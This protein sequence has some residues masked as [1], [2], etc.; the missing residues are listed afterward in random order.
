[1][2]TN[3]WQQSSMQHFWGEIAPQ[4]HLVQFYEDDQSFL[5]TLEGFVGSGFIAKEGVIVIATGEHLKQLNERLTTNGFDLPKLIAGDFYMPIDA[6][7]A[8]ENFMVKGMPDETRFTKL[9]GGLIKRAKKNSGKFRAFGEMVAILLDKNQIEAM[10]HLEKLWNQ[11]CTKES[12]CLYCAYPKRN[13]TLTHSMDICSEHS[14]VI[15][16]VAGPSTQIRYKNIGTS[17]M[18]GQQ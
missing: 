13:K 4:D 9:V 3:D 11:F 17:L 12:F 2:V 1:M 18:R 15:S 8:L 10:I 7:E 16:G 5:N 14:K 6:E